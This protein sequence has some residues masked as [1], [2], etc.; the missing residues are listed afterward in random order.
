VTDF[1][2]VRDPPERLGELAAA[3]G[4]TAAEILAD[5]MSDMGFVVNDRFSA[6]YEW[7]MYHEHPVRSAD[8]LAHRRLQDY[9]VFCTA[10]RDA[11]EAALRSVHGAPRE[12][13]GRLRY[14]PFFVSG[15]ERF[16]LA[17]YAREPDWAA[18]PVDPAVRIAEV[19]AIAAAIERAETI[20]EAQ[21]A[22]G[23]ASLRLHPPMP[24]EDAAHALGVPGA[25]PA[26]VD[27]HMSHWVL[28]VPLGRWRVEATV[29]GDVVRWIGLY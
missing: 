12:V 9:T 21:A 14:G 16:N 27:V 25:E 17:W 7:D 10:G 2:F 24:K 5:G 26:A 23:G 29:D 15:D 19:Q 13:A 3:L 18:P 8:D 4:L 11:C 20:E 6:R 28:R 1:A 22:L